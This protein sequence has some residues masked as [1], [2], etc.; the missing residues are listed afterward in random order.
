MFI[1]KNYAIEITPRRLKPIIHL[2][3]WVFFVHEG[4]HL[5]ESLLRVTS[6]AQTV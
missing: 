3:G 6:V 2:R 1:S 4:G 5:A